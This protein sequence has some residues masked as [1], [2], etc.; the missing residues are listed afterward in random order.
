M[1]QPEYTWPVRIIRSRRKTVSIE[2][3]PQ[4]ILV[5]AP[6]FMPDA[7]IRA[8]LKQKE[9]WIVKHQALVEERQK[10]LS[11]ESKFTEED[12]QA[13]AEMAVRVLPEKVRFFAE[14]I[15]VDFG[16]VTVRCQKTRWGSCSGKGNLNFNCL[17]MLFPDEVI[18]SVVVHELCH[19]K[20][21]NHSAAFYAEIERVL[22][23]YKKQQL[24]LKEN[25]GRY[26]R[27][28]P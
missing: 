17:L 24:W 10:T 20:H 12:I 19:R 21:M 28:L 15:G 25:G 23:D 22:P 3:K 18:D 5:R 13:L 8:L 4:E 16:R 1:P 2:I 11:Q 26:L 6:I 27:R 7:E 9:N 14:R